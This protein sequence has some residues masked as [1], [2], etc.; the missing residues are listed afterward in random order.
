MKNENI[1][2]LT[3]CIL[4]IAFGSTA[5]MAQE[6]FDG[7]QPVQEDGSADRGRIIRELGLT[8]DQIRQIRVL[9]ADRRPR[10][11]EALQRLRQAQRDLDR[12]T[13]ADDLDEAAI[14][15]H[16]KG[17]ISAQAEL[18][19]IRATDELE[20]RKI[21]TPEQLIKFREVRQRAQEMRNNPQQR[22]QD[23]LQNAPQP[24]IN[25]PNRPQNN[26]VTRPNRPGRT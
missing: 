21:L 14:Q 11:V 16:L 6:R 13:Y 8:Q 5:S 25:R 26:Q 15:T 20:M 10:M 4:F 1:I 23:R 24:P 19:E 17:F 12:A 7:N 22:R 2:I 18:A 9:R 3:L